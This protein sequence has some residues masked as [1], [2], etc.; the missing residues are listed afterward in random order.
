MKI[1]LFDGVCSLCNGAMAFIARRDCK[2]LFHFAS[3][4]SDA[5]IALLKEAGMPV[6]G[7][8]T[9]VYLR[10][11]HP[12]IRSSAVLHILRDMGGGWQLMYGLIV[13]PRFIRD[14]VYRLVAAMR[15]RIGKKQKACPIMPP[16]IRSRFL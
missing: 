9:L 11:G 16:G 15:H 10:E 8:D 13:T 5:G 3:L 12:Y 7:L 14:A 4:Q 6:K 2:A 1:I